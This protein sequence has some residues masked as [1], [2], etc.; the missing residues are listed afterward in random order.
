MLL[1][2][3]AT[4]P[5]VEGREPVGKGCGLLQP[6]FFYR[7]P[8]GPGYAL[9]GDAGHFKDFVTGQGMADALLDAERLA[10]AILDGRPEAFDVYW[11]AR[12]VETL[13]L[14]FDAI[15]QGK[16]G[17]NAPFM[18][19]VYAHLGRDEALASRLGLV[20][21]RQIPPSATIGTGK[22]LAWVGEALLR[23]RLDVVRGFFRM[24]KELGGEERELTARRA[25]LSVAMERLAGS[26]PRTT[27][28]ALERAA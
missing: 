22:M 21:D 16:I 18:R 9:L 10:T 25:L 13:P 17:F 15:R 24:G 11:R 7:D 2:S 4:R 26:P 20:M 6:R 5:L 3:P 14:H 19:W 27:L 1:S 12:D 8:V 28:T 23:G